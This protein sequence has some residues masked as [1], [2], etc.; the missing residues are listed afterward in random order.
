MPM[1]EHTQAPAD[2]TTSLPAHVDVLVVGA[3]FSGVGAAIR[4]SRE[5]F[6]D[7][8]VVD[9]GAD[10]GGTWR[11]NDYPGAA[12]DVPSH[13]YSFSFALNP[14]WTRTFSP[15]AEIFEYLRRTAREAG[16]LPRFRFG[17][18]VRSAR[19]D[20][21]A[22]LWRVSTSAGDITSR[23]LILGVGPLCEPNLPDIPGIEGFEGEI[24]HSARW[25]HDVPLRGRRAA[26]I[27]TGAS[28]IQIVPSIAPEVGHLDVYQR[29]APWILPRVDRPYTPPER[30]AFRR[31]PAFR[32]WVR[33]QIYLTRESQVVGLT[34]ARALLKPLETAAR[35]LLRFQVR[36]P[37]LRRRLTPGY[38]LG[39]K[40]ILLSNKY[41][42][43]I[44]RPNVDL[45]TS[46]IREIRGRSIVTEDGAEHETDVLVVATG[47]HVTDSPAFG[48]IRG[49][50]GRSLAEV[51][52]EGGMTAYK[53]TTVHNFPNMFVLIGP[54]T[55]LGHSSMIFMI[56]SQLNYL[57]GAL[58]SMRDR[59]ES[60]IEVREDVQEAYNEDIRRRVDESIWMTGGCSSWYKDVHGNAP[61]VWP[62][63]TFVF[64][65]LTK[66]FDPNAYLRVSVP[67]STD[68]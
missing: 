67:A 49:R 11:D 23:I 41:Y 33:G 44:A 43:A 26:V 15:Q 29:T 60:V 53:G 21:D 66:D 59:G 58:R 25:R 65:R 10:V 63:Y 37:E 52:E 22:A 51:W 6:D 9:R 14:G 36:D 57:L 19:W 20:E 56:E 62:D 4:M 12:C 61:A 32:T 39:C 3:G 16:V 42:P 47:F 54:A 40:R 5:G 17:V 27:G 13:L 64:R 18:E 55:G 7:F 8:L 28:A 35:A 38:S 30:L 50:D 46:P 1:T 68:S 2:P 45:V 34:R 31:I 48:I 24:M